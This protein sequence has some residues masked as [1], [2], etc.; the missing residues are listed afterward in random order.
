M[1]KGIG[2]A[3]ILAFSYKDSIKSGEDKLKKYEATALHATPLTSPAPILFLML[4]S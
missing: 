3:V 1:G 4:Y 2:A